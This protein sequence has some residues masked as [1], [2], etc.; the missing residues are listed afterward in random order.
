MINR[1]LALAIFTFTIHTS[2]SQSLAVSEIARI[3]DPIDE[4][5]GM[6]FYND[7]FILI[8]DSGNRPELYFLDT[9]YKL[10]RTIALEE[11]QNQDWEELAVSPNGILYIGDFGNNNNNRRD[12]KVYIYDVKRSKE[13][14]AEYV[15]IIDFTYP[16]QYAFPPDNCCLYFDNEAMIFADNQLFLF[17][18]NRTKPFNGK[19]YIYSLPPVPGRYI[20]EIRDSVVTGKGLM[21]SN[22]IAAADYNVELNEVAL[23]GYD[24]VWILYN[25]LQ[26]DGK[27]NT[28]Q[29]ATKITGY[30]SQ[31]E[32]ICYKDNKIYIGDERTAGSG[33]ML[34]VVKAKRQQT[35]VSIKSKIVKDELKLN[36]KY[37]H[38]ESLKWEIF[39]TNGIRMISGLEDNLGLNKMDKLKID[40]SRLDPGGYVLNVL[41]NDEPNAFKFKILLENP[42]E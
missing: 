13:G 18:K 2:F 7:E 17:T 12:L 41:L 39:N 22:W 33:Q 19:S 14:I 30:I 40:V 20:A 16:N 24:K 34:Y 3:P 36:F 1:I 6:V 4:C 35:Q 28:N 5:S 15:G 21:H 11:A 42:A 37:P 23:L 29:V 27:T 8:N 9:D 31:K 25:F 38:G 10:I 26:K 32:A